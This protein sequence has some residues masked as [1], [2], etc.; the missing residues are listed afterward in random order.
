PLL[1]ATFAELPVPVIYKTNWREI[2]SSL[3]KA[4]KKFHENKPN[5]ILAHGDKDAFKD[6]VI[7][8]SIKKFE[9]EEL[10]KVF[11]LNIKGKL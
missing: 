1:T 4:C 8:G 10:I 5:F 9:F 3:S 6:F 2:E 11:C 7:N